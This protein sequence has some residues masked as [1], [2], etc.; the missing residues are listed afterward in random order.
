MNQLVLSGTATLVLSRTRSSCYRGPE[1]S[2]RSCFS[3]RSNHSDATNQ[4]SFGFLLTD[5]TASRIGDDWQRR[6]L[7]PTCPCKP[8]TPLTESQAHGVQLQ[9]QGAEA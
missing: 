1:S 7:G 8:H 4:K 5:Q 6:A 2:L 9:L 3:T